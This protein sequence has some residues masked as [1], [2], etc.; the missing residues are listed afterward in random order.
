MNIDDS[1]LEYDGSFPGLLCAVAEALNEEAS[2]GRLPAVRSEKALCGLFEDRR[3]VVRDEARAASLWKRL[4][5]RAGEEVMFTALD[6]YS[7]DREGVDEALVLA[8]SRVWHQGGGALNELGDPSILLVE[9]AA[10]CT[11]AEAHL[12]KGLVRFSELSDGSWYASIRPECSLLHL[13]GDHFSQRFP[14]MRWLIHDRRRAKAILHERQRPWT[15]V[16]GFELNEPKAEDG[17]ALPLYSE[18]ESSLRAAWARYFDSVAIAERT[19]PRLQ[20]NHMPKKY[21][22]DLPELARE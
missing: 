20:A 13:L 4:A 12:M 17:Q 18:Q 15:L 22:P 14:D 8:L 10:T 7:S 6:A 19:N 21:W 5:R 2:C 16:E 9:Q 11:R 3:P 1:V